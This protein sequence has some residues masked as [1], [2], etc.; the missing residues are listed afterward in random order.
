LLSTP[1]ETPG[2]A[3]SVRF[4]PFLGSSFRLSKNPLASPVQNCS[5]PFTSFSLFFC[6][7]SSFGGTLPSTPKTRISW[8]PQIPVRLSSPFL[9]FSFRDGRHFTSNFPQGNVRLRL[10]ESIHCTFSFYPAKAP[11]LEGLLATLCHLKT[12]HLPCRYLS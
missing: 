1:A 11:T 4:P 9:Y 7:C 5:L 2:F 6:Y 8:A 10:E 3:L 12:F